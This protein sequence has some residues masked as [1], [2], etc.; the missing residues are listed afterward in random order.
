MLIITQRI[1]FLEPLWLDLE[2]SRLETKTYLISKRTNAYDVV[3]KN[4]EII[5]NF[6]VMEISRVYSDVSGI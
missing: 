6:S 1:P 3:Y 5:G 2:F 4:G